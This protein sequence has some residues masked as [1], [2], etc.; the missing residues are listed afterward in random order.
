MVS[1]VLNIWAPERENNIR[2]LLYSW[3]Q[4][5]SLSGSSFSSHCF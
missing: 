2:A 1:Q 5:E 4:R 3:V